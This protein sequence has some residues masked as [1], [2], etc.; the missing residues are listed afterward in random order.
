MSDSDGMSSGY[1]SEKIFVRLRE[2]DK[3]PEWAETLCREVAEASG[4][5]LTAFYRIPGGKKVPRWAYLSAQT[6]YVSVP[7]RLPMEREDLSIAVETGLTVVQNSPAGPFPG[8]LLSEKM[9]SGVAICLGDPKIVYGVLVANHGS[10]F[11]YTAEVIGLLEGL[12]RLMGRPG[13]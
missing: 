13:A 6:G 4:S 8:L 9:R 5:E 10:P 1:G 2:R 12:G 11:F 7:E 3:V